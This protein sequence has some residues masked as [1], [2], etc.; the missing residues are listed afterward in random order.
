MISGAAGSA[1]SIEQAV[2]GLTEALIVVLNDKEN[3]SELDI[4]SV[5]NVAL[6]SGGNSSSEHVLQM[7]RQLPAKTLSKQIGS[8]E[9]TEDVNADGSKTSADRRELHVKRT[10]KWLE[11]T[12]NNVDKLLSATFP[13]LSIHSS[14]KVRRSVVNG[15]RVLLSSCS[16]TLRKSKMLLVECLCILACDDAASVSEAAQDSLDYLFIEGE[17]VLTE[18]DVSDIFTRFVEKLPQMVLGSEETTAISHARRLLALT[19]YAG[20]QFLANYLHRSPV[21]YLH[22]FCWINDSF[23]FNFILFHF[24]VVAARL[25]DCLGLCI[26][27]SSQFSGSMDKLIVSKPLSVGYLF[28]VAELKSGAYPKDENYGFQ[29]AMPAS[30]ATKISVIHDNGLP[31]TTHSSVDYE[32][33]H[34]PPWFVHVNSQK[35][36][37]A[38]AGIVRLVGLSAVSGTFSTML[39]ACQHYHLGLISVLHFVS[40]GATYGT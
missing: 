23:A 35:L 13:H 37:F 20:P 17:R 10:K 39:Y 4:S 40:S 24:Q 6:C 7:L 21:S 34:V 11:E 18:D 25:F 9:A 27:Q 30:T 26:S 5:E 19:Y 2:L 33:P 8:G 28:S 16:Y 12:A 1:L 36:Y 32:L 3:L 31:N 15:I 14:E 29:H 22:P 38:L